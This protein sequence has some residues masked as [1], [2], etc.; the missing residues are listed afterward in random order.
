MWGIAAAAYTGVVNQVRRE[1]GFHATHIRRFQVR[2]GLLWL[3]FFSFWHTYITVSKQSVLNLS[4]CLQ[5]TAPNST[6]VVARSPNQASGMTIQ[7]TLMHP[8][9]FVVSQ[10]PCASFMQNKT[11]P[12]PPL[13]ISKYPRYTTPPN[14]NPPPPPN[15]P[16]TPPPLPT[17]RRPPAPPLAPPPWPA[18]PYAAPPAATAHRTAS[19]GPRA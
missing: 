16:I 4:L 7:N 8:N 11:N 12:N 2:F 6:L 14:P 1:R 9:R 3:R 5:T 17:P 10:H 18:P 19:T 13:S 15:Q